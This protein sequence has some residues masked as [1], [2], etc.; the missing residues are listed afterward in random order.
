MVYVLVYLWVGVIL[1]AM[2]R[3]GCVCG[4]FP[5]KPNTIDYF[6]VTFFWPVAVIVSLLVVV[7]DIIYYLV[8]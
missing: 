6:V 2:Y 7:F 8:R 4:K 5:T 1:S 3:N